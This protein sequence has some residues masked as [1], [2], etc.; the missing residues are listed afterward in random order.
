MSLLEVLI[1]LLVFSFGLI[2]LVGLQ[3]R[4]V[5]FS[6]SAED[7]NRA[8]LLANEI[9]TEMLT[10]QAVVLPAARVATWQSRVGNPVADGLPNGQGEIT[11]DTAT[12]LATITIRWRSPKAASGAAN[13]E[14]Q[15]VTHVKVVT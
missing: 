6:V 4:A 7:T 9:A 12:G 1:S 3:I 8:A 14:N 13:S 15:Y 2:G 11:V 5:G 10:S